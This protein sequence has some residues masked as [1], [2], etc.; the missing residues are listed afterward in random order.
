MAKFCVHCG[1]NLEEGSNVCPNCGAKV[2]EMKEE[3][4]ETVVVNEPNRQA[5]TAP[6]AQAQPAKNPTNGLAI[7]GFII[8][9]VSAI[10][11]CGAL[12]PISLI[13]SIIGVADANKKNGSGKGLAIAGIIISVLALLVAI[14]IWLLVGIG[15]FAEMF[16][17]IEYSI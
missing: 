4:V 10:L 1:S 8:S 2:E 7:A 15:T 9:L 6:A 14:V 13:L 16:E 3:V 12:S 5:Y 17:E 11:C